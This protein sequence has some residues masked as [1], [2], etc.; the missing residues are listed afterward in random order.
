MKIYPILSIIFGSISIFISVFAVIAAV[1]TR[2]ICFKLKNQVDTL[3]KHNKYQQNE[4]I[5][6]REH[7]GKL[8]DEN[9]ILKR[10][11]GIDKLP[12]FRQDW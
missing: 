3:R 2:R 6:L 7:N 9:A 8:Y 4:I 1:R 5:R 12:D 10:T 11:L